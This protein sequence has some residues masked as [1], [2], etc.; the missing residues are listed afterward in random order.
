MKT[1]I[2]PAQITT[3]EDKVAGNLSL[4]QLFLLSA[5]IFIG[6]LVYLIF[7]PFMGAASYKLVIVFVQSGLSSTH[8]LT[9][10]LHNG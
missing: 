1:S 4:P 8:S 10:R 7:P 6:S 3:V 9:P 5:P 2:V